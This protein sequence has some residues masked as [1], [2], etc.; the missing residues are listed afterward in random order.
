MQSITPVVYPEL[1]GRHAGFAEN[2]RAA[3]TV[4]VRARAA[5]RGQHR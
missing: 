2:S 1:P 3:S 5:Q 4:E